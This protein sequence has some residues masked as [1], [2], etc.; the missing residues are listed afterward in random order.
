MV[1]VTTTVTA[2]LFPSEE[3]S[4]ALTEY[5]A[6]YTAVLN[7]VSHVAFESQCQNFRTLHDDNYYSLRRL[8]RL[9]SQAVIS[10]EKEVV[11]KYKTVHARVPKNG[12]WK[13]YVR[14][15][16][17]TTSLVY[18]RDY[19]LKFA[20]GEFTAS[21]Q[22]LN[23]RIKG[24][25]VTGL[26][27]D[28]M[29]DESTRIGTATLNHR[30]GKW[31]LHVPVTRDIPAASLTDVRN[32]VGVD[33]GIRHLAV[34]YDSRGKTR[35]YR[36]GEVKNKRA[37]YKSLRTELQRKG[38]PSSRRRLRAIGSRESRWMS[39]VNHVVSK[40]LVEHAGDAALIVVED[41]TG[42]R[43]ATE[44]VKR[45]HRYVQ[46]SW[47]FHDLR[48]KIEYKAALAG[49]RC[50]AV[51]P[52]Y[53]SQKCPKCGHIEA[54]NRDK[55]GHR[56]LCKRCAYRSNDD[57]IGAMNLHN[58]G[59]QY[60]VQCELGTPDSQGCIQPAHDAPSIQGGSVPSGARL[61]A[62]QEQTPSVRAG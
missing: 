36:G 26:D 8:Y 58:K 48:Q 2:R 34:T 5:L 29:N 4:A 17:H 18:A 21:L 14:F 31:I 52:R 44:R 41:L 60:R 54:G 57:R 61:T 42:V 12:R 3:Q 45:K 33:M 22:S 51:S 40:A 20:D 47:A 6:E 28:L 32:V 24:V 1:E 23:G 49:S 13:S 53:T 7:H 50:V 38:T 56:F 46:V 59:I 39:D 16:K 43:N 62:G 30:R 25:P 27:P 19:S 55:R 9:G 15:R 37:H 10:A 35:F 11:A